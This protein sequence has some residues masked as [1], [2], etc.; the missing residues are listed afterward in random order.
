MTL[1]QHLFTY[2]PFMA[3]HFVVFI[4]LA[5]HRLLYVDVFTTT[6]KERHFTVMPSSSSTTSDKPI[7]RKR[8]FRS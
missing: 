6:V 4:L 5:F 7:H 3:F 2:F 8:A 1:R